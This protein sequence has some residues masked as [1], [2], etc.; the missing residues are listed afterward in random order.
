[1]VR[2]LLI[3][4]A[5]CVAAA[6][7]MQRY[8]STATAVTG[9]PGS[10]QLQ[11][12]LPGSTIYVC[13]GATQPCVAPGTAALYSDIAGRFP[14]AQPLV[15]DA[16][17][18]FGFYWGGATITWT[19]TPPSGAIG[20][21][22]SK[23]IT[24]PYNTQTISVATPAPAAPSSVTV[25]PVGT[26]GATTYYYWVVSDFTIGNSAP[27]LAAVIKNAAPTLSTINY[28]KV[29]WSTVSGANTYDVL[30]TT[31]ATAPSGACA[32]AVAT[33]VNALT[34][35]DQSNSLSAYT[36]N[37]YAG[38]TTFNITNAAAG[39]GE[40][41]L[42]F[43]ADHGAQF[44]ID[45]VNGASFTTIN[46]TSPAIT[47]TSIERVYL[48]DQFVGTT[49]NA[50]LASAIAAIGSSSA[51]LFVPSNVQC[52]ITANQ[53]IPAN[54]SLRLAQ[55][56]T[57]DPG[58]GVT[59]TINGD[60]APASYQILGGVGT[61][62]FASNY[63]V[64][65]LNIEW[66]GAVGDDSTI[67]TTAVQAAMTASEHSASIPVEIPSGTFLVCNVQAG[68]PATKASAGQSTAAPGAYGIIGTGRFTS[69]LKATALCSG[70]VLQRN[71]TA[72]KTYQGFG[73]DGAT[74]AK[75]ADFSWL[76]GSPSTSDVFHE[77]LIQNCNGGGLD[78]DNQN[79]GPVSDVQVRQEQSHTDVAL[80]WNAGTGP[81]G[82][83]NIV[84]N[85]GTMDIGA[86]NFNCTNCSAYDGVDIVGS[87]YNFGLWTGGQIW[88]NA[89]TGVA[90]NNL[91]TGS[92]GAYAM[93]FEGVQFDAASGQSVFAGNWGGTVRVESS[94]ATGG[95]AWFGTLTNGS[96]F[97]GTPQFQIVH[98]S[99]PALPFAISSG[100]GYTAQWY[101]DGSNY[102]VLYSSL[103]RTETTPFFQVSAPSGGYGFFCGAGTCGASNYLI[104][105]NGAAAY[106]GEGY[107]TINA[108]AMFA[109]TAGGSLASGQTF[110]NGGTISGGVV[111]ATTLEQGSQAVALSGANGVSAGTVTLT[112]GAGSHAFTAVYTAAPVCVATDTTAPNAVQASSSTT[113]V[114]LAGNGADVIAWECSPAV[115]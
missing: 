98:S 76:A 79:D 102:T 63:A 41:K 115:N 31:A 82:G 60:I 59:L 97:G 67:S 1:M 87:S 15:A 18:N 3:I 57:L 78:L 104:G 6:A 74:I 86:Q 45:N 114:T 37:T 100:Y 13:T 91:A 72:G 107:T 5:L 8:D 25:T 75:G 61:V 14:L 51:V 101:T 93:A 23:T 21:V 49:C 11:A 84:V 4:A 44:T 48:L 64:H 16:S 52:A 40:S 66:W 42:T 39:A 50:Q 89:S 54:V 46:S 70:W 56:G 110:T 9:Q 83:N 111:N 24:A 58:A 33:A 7:Q 36:V 96:A 20:A 19:A 65:A 10:I 108:A 30:R 28:D 43:A 32:C 73:V 92:P 69:M 99:G 105:G 81:V 29:S 35:N 17:G 113:S 77:L 88:A 103:T 95:G 109:L 12:V 2:K 26:T 94:G 90:V 53:T 71:N 38:D 27:S 112:A 68:D 85:I 22:Q 80:S 62:S 55:G 106:I 34:A 47:P